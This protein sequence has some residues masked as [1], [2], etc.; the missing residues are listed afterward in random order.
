M[1]T[2]LTGVGPVETTVPWGRDG[3]FES[4]IVKKR[5]QLLTGVGEK[6]SSLS[7]KGLTTGGVQAHLTEVHGAHVSRQTISTLTDKVLEGIAERK[8]STGVCSRRPGR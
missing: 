3:V 4:K 8:T 6:G 7:T 5:P 2:V 1:R